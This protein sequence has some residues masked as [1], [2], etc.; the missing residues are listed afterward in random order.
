MT[1]AQEEVGFEAMVEY[2]W[3]R[4]NTDV[5]FIATQSILDLCEE[6]EITPGLWVR[7]HW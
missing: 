2:T 4:Q 7:I 3:I 6:T 1:A 5:Q